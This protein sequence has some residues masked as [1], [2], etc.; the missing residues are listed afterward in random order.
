MT[1]AHRAVAP[2]VAAASGPAPRPR[3][4][5]LGLHPRSGPGTIYSLLTRLIAT[6]SAESR[7]DLGSATGLARSTVGDH[8]DR[9]LAAGVLVEGGT[10]ARGGRGRPP[11]RLALNRRAAVVG[12]AALG[13]RRAR[14]AVAD[15]AQTVLAEEELLLDVARG[16]EHC[17]DVV[18]ERLRRLLAARGYG[19]EA[20]GV[21]VVGVPGPVD[22]RAGTPV[23]PP[24]MPGWDEYPLGAVLSER[25][26]CPALVDNDVNLMALGEARSLDPG[27]LPLLF[28][29]IGTGIGGGLVSASGELHRGADG[30]AGD[31]GHIRVPGG[32][33]VVCRCGNIGCVEAVASA[34]AMLERVRRAGTGSAHRD[35][36]GSAAPE[37][38]EPR[39]IDDLRALLR[40][41]DPEAVRVVRE[42]AAAIGEITALLVHVYNPARIVLGGAVSQDS[43]DLLA[44]VRGV[45]YR[46]AL[47]LA[48][49]HLTLAPS[50]LGPSAGV[51]GGIVLGVEHILSPDG[52][53][54]L[55]AAAAAGAAG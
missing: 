52:I 14:V 38:R 49:R 27:E 39:H 3:L 32:D 20:V 51:T 19:A 21:V 25:F 10:V 45:V 41:G 43:D 17:V 6:G 34:A 18:T 7:V 23:R 4:S 53:S 26:G 29:K 9:L 33:D 16:P 36:R 1:A 37:R 30:S 24:I 46:R 31:I 8:L 28:L 5:L 48:T 22:V 12:V 15:L 35:P 2:S 13:A 50:V 11:Q 47:P 55:M 44:G 54:H 40:A 42:S